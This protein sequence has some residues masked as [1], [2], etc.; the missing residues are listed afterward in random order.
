VINITR[1]YQQSLKC[2]TIENFNKA[3]EKIKRVQES[4]IPAKNIFESIQRDSAEIHRITK[5]L[6]QARS[7]RNDRFFTDLENMVLKR[8]LIDQSIIFT[9]FASALK[10]YPQIVGPAATALG[11]FYAV[12]KTGQFLEEWRVGDKPIDEYLKVVGDS[13]ENLA[14]VEPLELQIVSQDISEQLSQ[15]EQLKRNFEAQQGLFLHLDLV[16]GATNE[17]IDIRSKLEK[18][19]KDP[20]TQIVKIE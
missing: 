9:T 8:D 4:D 5:E 19:F 11:S 6:D 14:S 3:F 17:A 2:K 20:I 18:T 16:D 1:A 10:Q 7:D 15:V 12:W 13:F